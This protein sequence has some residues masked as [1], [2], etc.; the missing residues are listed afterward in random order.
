MNDVKAHGNNMDA[1]FGEV[2]D[3][4][5]KMPAGAN[6]TAVATKLFGR[7][8]QTLLPLLSGGSKGME[9][10]TKQAE[11]M[12]VNFGGNGQKSM[13][14]M[15]AAMV[16]VNLA[17]TGLKVA[18]AQEIAP[19]LF[20]VLGVVVQLAGVLLKNLHPAF[21][22][23]GS[24]VN[25]VTTFFKQHQ[26]VLHA[27]MIV[28]GLLIAQ[29]VYGKAVILA[30]RAALALLTLAQNL[31]KVA[32]FAYKVAVLAVR[33]AMLIWQGTIWLVNAALDANPIAI[34]IIAIIALI[35]II[36]LVIT[37]FTQVKNVIVSGWNIIKGAFMTA[38]N[39]V[40]NF[41]KKNWPLLV[42]IFGG[43]IGL[44]IGLFFKFKSQVIQ[45][46]TDVWN[47]MKKLPG[48]IVSAMS[49]IGNKIAQPFKA[50]FQWVMD[51]LPH[52]SISTGHWH[53]I[54]YPKISFA[55]G[56]IMPYAGTALVGEAGPE[57][58][59][60]PRGAS[61]TPLNRTSNF[62]TVNQGNYGGIPPIMVSVQVDR[63]EIARAVA[64]AND[65]I[66]ARK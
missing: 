34:V 59:H 58:L 53:G 44:I 25:G 32:M 8:W 23:L 18:F 22:I 48:R 17:T 37:H 3:K 30:A 64:K 40:I 63:K 61:V 26:T 62:T 31:G 52:P 11:S 7:S 27:V 51:H 9:A 47:F 56:G 5:N 38:I 15:R 43:P 57:I 39:F 49:G 65:D 20:Q 16:Q 54:P 10:L 12:G 24:I 55:T 4:F 50:G 66:K 1:M 2:V 6:K 21:K 19:T 13:M 29:W 36:V 35:A 45:A 28:V 60:L 46:A 33:A 14:Q 41:V 42:G